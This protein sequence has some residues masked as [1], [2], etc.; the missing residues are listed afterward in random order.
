M[1]YGRMR[2]FKSWSTRS[3]CPP[4]AS[5]HRTVRRPAELFRFA[6]PIHVHPNLQNPSAGDSKHVHARHVDAL[7]GRRMAEE[8]AALRSTDAPP[9]GHL[10]ALG[11]LVLD[12]EPKIGKGGTDAADDILELRSAPRD[13]GRVSKH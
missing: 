4:E 12:R 5:R 7:A 9:G 6:Q 11:E 2:G 10:V 13:D 1:N 3:A 8:R